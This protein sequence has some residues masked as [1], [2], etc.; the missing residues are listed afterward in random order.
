MLRGQSLTL[1]LDINSKGGACRSEAV[2]GCLGLP[3]GV[4]HKGSLQM[5]SGC[6]PPVLDAAGV[7]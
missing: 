5:S 7:V 1:H 6:Q 3:V 2:C 4:G